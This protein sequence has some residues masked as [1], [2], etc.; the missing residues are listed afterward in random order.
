MNLDASAIEALPAAKPRS[1]SGLLRILGFWDGMAVVIGVIIG[2]GILRTPGIIAG[3]LGQ[4]AVIFGVWVLGAC[5][6]LGS[7]LVLAELV[8]LLPRVGGKYVYA[9]TAFGPLAGFVTGWSELLTRGLTAAAK[10]VVVAEYT[11]R[12][13]GAGSTRVVAALV[14][15][16]FAMLHWF[17]LRPVRAFQ[18]AA[19]VAKVAILLGVTALAFAFGPGFDWQAAATTPATALGWV[20]AIAL[21]FQVVTFTYYGYDEATKLAEEIR[22]PRKQ[23]PR[24]LTFGILAVAVIYLAVNAA[25]LYVLSPAEMADSPLVAADVAARLGGTGAGALVTLAALLILLS[26]LNVNILSL[27]RVGLALAQD[28]LAFGRMTRVSA[29]GAPRTALLVA[30]AIVLAAAPLG[31]FQSLVLVI[32]WIV[33]VV[34]GLVILGLFHLRRRH[35]DWPRPYR[36]PLYPVLPAL[37]LAAYAALL[38]GVTIGYPQSAAV[39]AG[40]LVVLVLAGLLRLRTSTAAA[41]ATIPMPESD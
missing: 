9:R 31:S 41:T 19:T 36:V 13:M 6:A 23:L 28:G 7:A 26:S 5:L 25:F 10:T 32:M 40:A 3:Q 18:N 39:A 12:L 16:V 1:R 34:D 33:L 4:P 22:D 27:P 38:V 8:A 24:V 30:I 21:A 14:A 29:G 20:G 15:L 37:V 17:G 11:V 2:S 35:P